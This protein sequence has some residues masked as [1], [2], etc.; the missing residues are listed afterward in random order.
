MVRYQSQAVLSRTKA[1]GPLTLV[2]VTLD[3]TFYPKQPRDAKGRFMLT[4]G[5]VALAP[6][7]AV[8]A[9]SAVE[10]APISMDEAAEVWNGRHSPHLPEVRGT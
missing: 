8:E 5:K 10:A 1:T 4:R 6:L 7:T 3:S 9:D 2:G